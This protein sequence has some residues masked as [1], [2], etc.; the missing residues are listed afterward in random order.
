MGNVSR[1][2]VVL[3]VSMLMLHV[4]M[5]V[6]DVIAQPCFYSS[7]AYTILYSYTIEIA[8]LKLSLHR[9]SFL[10]RS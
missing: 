6:I 9:C 4:S 10:V 5:L 7:R 2:K 3:K 1:N 8:V